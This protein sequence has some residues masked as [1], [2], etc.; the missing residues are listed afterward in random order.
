MRLYI[1]FFLFLCLFGAPG[2]GGSDVLASD[3]ETGP[4]SG[5]Y[6]TLTP[7]EQAWLKA[8]PVIRLGF[9]VDRPPYE[10][11]DAQ[12]DMAGIVADYFQLFETRLGVTFERRCKLNGSSLSWTEI[13][14]AAREKQLDVV[15][16]VIW[17]KE[18]ENHL[19]FT[20]PYTQF[21]WSFVTLRDAETTGKISNFYGQ[22]AAV[23]GSHPIVDQ[24]GYMHPELN[25]VLVNTPM[26]GLRAVYQGKVAIFVNNAAV[27]V[28]LIKKA[29]L[30]QLKVAGVLPGMD[31]Q[32]RVGRTQR[33]AHTWGNT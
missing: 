11:L 3:T 33:L 9:A 1:R 27:S 10:F 30:S 18:R 20:R 17:A 32:L 13:Q 26:Q 31:S 4:P 5:F 12:G 16:S 25:L 21:P 7:S 19:D 8:H 29:G 22:N 24:L 6:N 15:A 2:F 23:V 14:D 28:Y